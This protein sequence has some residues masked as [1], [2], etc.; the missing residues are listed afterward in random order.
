MIKRF[1]SWLFRRKLKTAPERITQE[2]PVVKLGAYELYEERR[3]LDTSLDRHYPADSGNG[4][5][6]RDDLE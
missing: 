1:L 6:W 4:R 5:Y 3:T 2:I